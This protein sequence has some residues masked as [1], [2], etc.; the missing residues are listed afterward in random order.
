M[1][2]VQMQLYDQ[3]LTLNKNAYPNP[4]PHQ[5]WTITLNTTVTNVIIAHSGLRVILLIKMK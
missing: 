3:T 4:N 1:Y 2:D 5:N